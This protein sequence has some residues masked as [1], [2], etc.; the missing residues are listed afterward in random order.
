VL[1]ALEAAADKSVIEKAWCNEMLV[2]YL[3]DCGLEKREG[4]RASRIRDFLERG[5]RPGYQSEFGT[6]TP[7]LLVILNPFSEIDELREVFSLMLREDPRS[8]LYRDGFN[9]TPL[10]WAIDYAAVAEQDG[11]P[12]NPATLLAFFPVLMSHLPPELDAGAACIKVSRSGFCAS[13]APQESSGPGRA[14]CRFLEG[15]R[16]KC[17]VENP[18]PSYGW[19]E[20]VVVGLWYREACWPQDHPGAPYEIRTDIGQRLFA[21]ADDDHIVRR[22]DASTRDRADVQRGQAAGGKRFVKQ[23]RANGSWELLDKVSGNDSAEEDDDDI[24]EGDDDGAAQMAKNAA[25]QAR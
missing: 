4:V 13:Q 22:E 20:G 7:L 25:L 2:Q 18:G 21:L 3:D 14:P 15:D 1:E 12:P 10:D 9:R 6:A 19:E 24:E 16:V 17:R 23:Q 5:A 11:V 8:A